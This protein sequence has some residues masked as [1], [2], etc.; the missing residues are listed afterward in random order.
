MDLFQYFDVP[1]FFDSSSMYFS[2]K[3]ERTQVN[4]N[5]LIQIFDLSTWMYTIFSVLSLSATFVAIYK[6]Y[7]SDLPEKVEKKTIRKLSFKALFF[8][9]LHWNHLDPLRDVVRR[10]SKPG[11][12]REAL[13][14][15]RLSGPHLEADVELLHHH[16]RVGLHLQLEGRAH[17]QGK[18]SPTPD[19]R[20]LH[21]LR[22]E[23][24]LPRH[25]Q[26][27]LRQ[28]PVLSGQRG[29]VDFPEFPASLLL[30]R[31]SWTLVRFLMSFP[32]RR[33]FEYDYYSVIQNTP[34]AI[35]TEEKNG[36]LWSKILNL[37]RGKT[38]D[39]HIASES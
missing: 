8:I 27:H 14:H 22:R 36:F 23:L 21:E 11:L 20:R 26:V 37:K 18:A 19:Q 38:Y 15:Q 5:A 17:P 24:D 6:F 34:R 35:G 33:S 16:D 30:V 10:I 29:Q 39:I 32:P 3:I 4:L 31:V 28:A 1:Y 13:G 12:H 7:H 25:G 9:G 2:H